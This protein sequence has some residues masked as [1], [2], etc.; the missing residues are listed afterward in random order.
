M[1]NTNE[2]SVEK[3][4]VTP[5]KLP[6]ELQM[7]P[8]GKKRD[9]ALDN[10]RGF[11][12]F[13]VFLWCCMFLPL[14]EFSWLQHTDKFGFGSWNDVL[15]WGIM[16]Y[17]MM[18]FAFC[19][20]LFMNINYLSKKEKFG[21]DGKARSY[22]IKRGLLLMGV[23][24]IE[25]LFK[26]IG[27]NTITDPYGWE[28]FMTFGFATIFCVLFL[29][30]KK[31]LRV[32]GGAILMAVYGVLAEFLPYAHDVLY[33][34]NMMP[35][36]SCFGA[37]GLAGVILWFSVLGELYKESKVKFLIGV[38]VLCILSIPSMVI[39]FLD[40]GEN[41]V[42]TTLVC[43]MNGWMRTFSINFYGFSIGF[44]LF[45]AAFASVMFLPFW[46]ITLLIK[47][48]IPFIATMGKNTLVFFFLYAISTIPTGLIY[49]AMPENLKPLAIFVNA[50]FVVAITFPI[51]YL[52]K[53]KN[54]I[55]H[56]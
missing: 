22:F 35:Y 56:V 53:R 54:W 51:A 37:I 3:T 5:E 41:G 12:I 49:G 40:F 6:N 47:R 23:G 33:T 45:G 50:L 13:I 15:G 30:R 11:V 29:G 16:D 55:V 44:L 28:I 42:G 19:L 24:G 26:D 39:T 36:G 4:D 38:L 31:W 52:F 27:D 43:D 20:G 34:C 32:L 46:A 25:L 2:L 17:G 18:M 8:Q 1:E 7:T 14:N 9:F 10:Y 21:S 48:E